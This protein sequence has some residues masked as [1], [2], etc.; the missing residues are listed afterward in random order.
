MFRSLIKLFPRLYMFMSVINLK[1]RLKNKPIIYSSNLSF[2]TYQKNRINSI[3]INLSSRVDRRNHMNGQL[4]SKFHWMNFSRF[5]AIIELN[6]ALG[7]AKSHL[8]VMH[9]WLLNGENDLLFVFEDDVII[10]LN[11]IELL[12]LIEKF[13]ISSFDVLCLGYN[14]ANRLKVDY[15]FSVSSSIKT[16]SCYIVKSHMKSEFISVYEKSIY[17]LEKGVD[18]SIAAVDLVWQEL[19]RKHYF[20]ITNDRYVVQMESFSDIQ[21]KVTN[22]GV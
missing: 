22:Y 6:G 7:C 18:S 4:K 3:Y 21:K 12:D 17:L 16:T 13:Q 20:C 10:N 11:S 19:Q 2:K 15:D 14:T 5:D 1:L 8:Q 9:S